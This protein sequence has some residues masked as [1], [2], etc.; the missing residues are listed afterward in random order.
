MFCPNCGK[1][2]PDGAAV[3][4]NCGEQLPDSDAGGSQDSAGS[5]PTTAYDS[6][7]TSYQTPRTVV[8]TEGG[9]NDRKAPKKKFP[10]GV[11]VVAV[12]VVC[13]LLAMVFR[14]SIPEPIRN[15][16]PDVPGITQHTHATQTTDATNSTETDNG[17]G[18]VSTGTSDTS[19]VSDTSSANG[20][21]SVANGDSTS[22]S[23]G[24]PSS[25]STSGSSSKQGT[26]SDLVGTWTG[27]FK[28]NPEFYGSQVNVPV[29]TIKSVDDSGKVHFDVKLNFH[30]H[31]SQQNGSTDGDEMLEFDDLV[32]IIQNDSFTYKFDVSKYG[33]KAQLA[34][35]VAIGGTKENRE[36]SAEVYSY[37]TTDYYDEYLMT[38]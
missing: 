35:T 24:S 30:N 33:D 19:E 13:L 21:E 6:L 31:D 17:E 1:P 5:V 9:K 14:E 22:S 11:I 27:T 16:I 2:V 18:V 34:M 29:L 12:I 3:C 28:G 20:S 36:M 32:A 25:D 23:T 7:G 37:L 26:Y 8:E 38:K 4:P 10:V 15:V